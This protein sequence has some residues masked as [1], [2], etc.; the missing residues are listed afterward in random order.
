MPDE[1]R[2][3]LVA[4]KKADGS[5][6]HITLQEFRKL[7]KNL[8]PNTP[9]VNNSP[10]FQKNNSV[11]ASAP[12]QKIIEPKIIQT[13]APQ[14]IVVRKENRIVEQ[15]EIVK[16][17]TPLSFSKQANGVAAKEDYSSLLE[18]KLALEEKSSGPLISAARE[19]EAEEIIGSLSFRVPEPN[20]KRL[21]NGI[22]LRLK[23]V[24]DEEQTRSFFLKSFEQGGVGLTKQ[25]VEEVLKLCSEKNLPQVI[26]SVLPLV[27]T[28]IPS[29]SYSNKI[30]LEN[31]KAVLEGKFQEKTMAPKTQIS[32]TS[33]DQHLD[34]IAKQ[35]EEPFKFIN[36]QPV[37]PIMRDV[38]SKEV[39]IGP[40]EELGV[41]TL[42]DFRHLAPSSEEAAARLGQKFINLKDE[43]I[44][45]YLQG[46]ESWRR[47]P[48]YTEYVAVLTEALGQ[49]KPLISLLTNKQKIQ[50]TEI[51]ALI[52]MERKV[53]L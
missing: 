44:L 18:E 10:S 13:Q 3:P 42:L 2:E 24:R 15:K 1:K 53:M 39:E 20:K 19:K 9:V 8:K 11:S 26:G 27:K 5:Y 49:K 34:T 4:I 17:K 22:Q 14:K 50:I 51:T 32:S 6:E 45:L 43:S 36:K 21:Q 46:I 23:D 41:I 25:Q 30:S 47:S 12:K 52:N 48:L 35:E 33:L 40:V 31:Q 38:V 29:A 7:K 16:E 37:R 28:N